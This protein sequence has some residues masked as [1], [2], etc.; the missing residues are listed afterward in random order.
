MLLV[1]PCTIQHLE[2]LLRGKAAFVDAFGLTVAPDYEL[3]P[4]PLHYSLNGL[5]AGKALPRWWAHL[6]ILNDSRTV[7]GIGGYKGNPDASGTVEI[8]YSIAPAYQ[9]R[10]LGT[11]AAYTLVSRAFKDAVVQT[12]QAHTLPHENPSTRVLQKVGMVFAGEV[13]DPEDGPIWRWAKTQ[14][15]LN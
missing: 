8:G 1:E 14:H 9:N 13:V 5:Q 7:I 2:V 3:T 12:V 11:E 10:G 6:F 4:E 15:P